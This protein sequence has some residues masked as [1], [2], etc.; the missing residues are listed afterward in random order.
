MFNCE[1]L[2]NGK[3]TIIQSILDEKMKDICNKYLTKTNIDKNSVIF[4]YS[5][6]RIKEEK[7]LKY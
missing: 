7:K 2:Y 5:G 6:N 1:F 3:I 4:L